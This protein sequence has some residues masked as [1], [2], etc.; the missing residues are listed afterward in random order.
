MDQRV[1]EFLYALYL[2]FSNVNIL[3]NHGIFVNTKKLI[4]VHYYYLNYRLQFIFHQ[5]FH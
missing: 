1:T 4:L 5:F 3:Q 2:A